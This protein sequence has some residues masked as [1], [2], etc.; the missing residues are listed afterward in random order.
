MKST[1]IRPGDRV[2]LSAVNG[3][4]S[5]PFTVLEVNRK[6]IIHDIYVQGANGQTW[7]ARSEGARIIS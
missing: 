1:N 4:G 5:R 3:L 7:P 2:I 6:D